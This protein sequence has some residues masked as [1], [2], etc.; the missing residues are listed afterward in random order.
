MA[1]KVFMFGSNGPYNHMGGNGS[2]IR[3]NYCLPYI[4]IY[5]FN[6]KIYSGYNGAWMSFYDEASSLGGQ[7]WDGTWAENIWDGK[8]FYIRSYYSGSYGAQGD[9][10][11]ANGSVTIGRDY[12]I[13]AVVVDCINNKLQFYNSSKDLILESKIESFKDKNIRGKIELT[14]HDSSGDFYLW[15]GSEQCPL[16]VEI[17]GILT[18][19][20][21]LNN[22]I[23]P[24]LYSNLKIK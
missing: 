15:D 11:A 19:S 9:I 8:C 24:V 17:P 1:E 13:V 7:N 12:G 22:R 10:T 18:L 4:Y 2:I 6:I 14:W 23:R 3:S 5:Q 21:A 16:Q 20:D